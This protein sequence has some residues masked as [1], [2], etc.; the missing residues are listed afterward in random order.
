VEEVAVELPDEHAAV[1]VA[2]AAIRVTATMLDGFR[3]VR[4]MRKTDTG[5]V[6]LR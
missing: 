1:T 4:P 2:S 3:R 5:G 6:P